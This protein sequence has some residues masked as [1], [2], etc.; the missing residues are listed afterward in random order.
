MV[1]PYFSGH[2]LRLPARRGLA[3]DREG[4]VH[5]QPP[6]HT[7]GGRGGLGGVQVRQFPVNFE[8]IS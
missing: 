2:K 5:H 8:H 4:W 7:E 6:T 1:S 3:G